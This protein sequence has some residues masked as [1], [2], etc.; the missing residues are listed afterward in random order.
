MSTAADQLAANLRALRKA[1]GMRS[2]DEL[3]QAS[4][5]PRPT[6]GVLENGRGNPT[7]EVLLKLAAALDVSIAELVGEQR[8]APKVHT[9]KGA[10]RGRA[11]DRDDLTA[12]TLRVLTKVAVVLERVEARLGEAPASHSQPRARRRRGA[13]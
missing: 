5:V 1:R 10:R 13:R 12:A 6:I 2:Q 7:L 3:A 11:G 4:G 8:D 9:G